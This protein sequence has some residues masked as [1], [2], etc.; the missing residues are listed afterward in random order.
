MVDFDQYYLHYRALWSLQ[1]ESICITSI[2]ER[3]R[4]RF[5]SR[6]S[7]QESCRNTRNPPW[8]SLQNCWKRLLFVWGTRKTDFLIEKL[9][10]TITLGEVLVE[11]GNSAQK[12]DVSRKL[13]TYL[14]QIDYD[15]YLCAGSTELEK[16]SKLID[17]LSSNK[18]LR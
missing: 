11:Y 10:S 5:T 12:A 8:I 9:K 16:A 7:V 2:I 14:E 18:Q 4:K 13:R 3:F 6:W 1:I 17:E 15:D